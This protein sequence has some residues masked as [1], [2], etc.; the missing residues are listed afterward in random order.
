M[1]SHD[2][3]FEALVRELGPALR[4]AILRACPAGMGIS[5]D[6]IEQEAL[7]KIWHAVESGREIANLP[8]YVRRIAVTTTIDAIRRVKARREEQLVLEADACRD[9]S[10]LHSDPKADRADS[11]DWRARAR[12]VGEK[13]E[14]CL[15]RMAEGR[16]EAVGLYIQGFTTFEIAEMLG[17]TEP[18]A[19]NLTY[20]GLDDL[21]ELLREEGIDYEAT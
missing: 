5:P 12:E 7:L 19:R 21:R 11:P 8:S 14:R 18:K 10:A 3:P 13:V 4:K 6:D 1:A 2:E 20:R 17:W 15:G 16:R 9:G